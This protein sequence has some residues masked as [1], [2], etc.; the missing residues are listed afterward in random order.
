MN[1]SVLAEI[2]ESVLSCGPTNHLTLISIQKVKSGNIAREIRASEG[3]G[4]G[5]DWNP[6]VPHPL[7]TRVGTRYTLELWGIKLRESERLVLLIR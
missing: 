5:G 3:A 7:K 6:R 4:G 2:C 1:I